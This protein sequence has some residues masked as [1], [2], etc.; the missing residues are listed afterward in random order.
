MSIPLGPLEENERYR[1]NVWPD[2]SGWHASPASSTEPQSND[3][4]T[5]VSPIPEAENEVLI[6]RKE[7]PPTV[8]RAASKTLLLEHTSSPSLSGGGDENTNL[9][10][11]DITETAGKSKSLMH[12][13]ELPSYNNQ[14]NSSEGGVI[15]EAEKVKTPEAAKIGCKPAMSFKTAADFTTT[16]GLSQMLIKV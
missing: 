4:S 11:I 8:S 14:F 12:E 16:A 10:G 3:I 1:C 15:E 9:H 13:H 6:L 2:I 7:S 5:L